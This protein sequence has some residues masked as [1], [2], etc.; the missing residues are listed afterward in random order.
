MQ[1]G[2]AV[3][4]VRADN[5]QV[6]H[7]HKAIADGGHAGYLPV[8]HALILHILPEPAVYLL[9]YLVDPRQPHLHKVALPGLKGLA[10][11]RVVSV[12]HCL[13]HYLPGALPAVA[14]LVQHD[15]HHLRDG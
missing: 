14:A 4:A 10:H 8:V 15:P 12:R 11:D 13:L 6:R 7:L 5:G 3:Y 2:H 9:D 1:G